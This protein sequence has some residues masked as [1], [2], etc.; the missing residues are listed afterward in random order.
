MSITVN[1]FIN[2]IADK[3]KNL[4]PDYDVYVDEIK[5]EQEL[6]NYFFIYVIDISQTNKLSTRCQ[7]VYNFDIFY[8]QP[9]NE[10]INFF[11]WTEKMMIEF[12]CLEVGND[13][14]HVTNTAFT[15]VDDVG[16]FTF[17]IKFYTLEIEDKDKMEKL[18]LHRGLKD[19]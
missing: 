6:S 10:N 4:Y 18:I 9:E 3:L 5:Q 11:D 14:Y 13:L 7:R 15:K 2:A 17:T 12:K 19:G 1:E 8:F 16:H